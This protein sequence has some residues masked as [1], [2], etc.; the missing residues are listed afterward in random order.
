MRINFT[1]LLLGYFFTVSSQDLSDSL[2][3][4]SYLIQA[5][6][7]GHKMQATGFFARYQRRLFFVTAAHCITGWDPFQFKKME[8]FPDTLF[9]RTSNDTGKLSYLSLP[10]ADIKRSTQPFHDYETPDV[11][12]IE[13]K[14]PK[15]Y[16]VYSVEKY[17]GERVRCET[18]KSIWISGYPHNEGYSDY[19]PDRQQPFTCNAE[20]GDAYCYYPF[21]AEA[22]RPDP[23]NYIAS[24]QEGAAAP[25]FCGAPAYLFTQNK[26]IVFGGLYIGSGGKALQSGM[27]VRPEYVIDKIVAEI[28][29]NKTAGR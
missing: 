19:L 27:V 23:L 3:K 18:I 16:P 17:F 6:T 8:N 15:K 26:H 14:N 2:S 5:K 10:V 21:R 11:Y 4:Y 28:N 24:L 1:L 9:I 22:K 29:N 25:G 13:T 7:A 12:V 20:L